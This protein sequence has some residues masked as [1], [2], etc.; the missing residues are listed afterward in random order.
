MREAVTRALLSFCLVSWL[1]GCSGNGAPPEPVPPPDPPPP[2]TVYT[3]EIRRTEYGIPHIMADDW[4]SL[5]YGYGYAYGQDRFCVAMAAIVF[6]TSR[7]AELLGEEYG[8]I[9]ADFVLRYLLGTK[10]EFRERYLSDP[11]DE[12]ILLAEGFAAGMNRYLRETG[13][14]NLPGGDEGCRDAALGLR[15]RCRRCLDAHRPGA[16]IRQFGPEHPA[17]GHDRAGRARRNRSRPATA[18][19][20]GRKSSAPWAGMPIRSGSEA[21]AAT[22]WRWDGI[23]AGRARACCSAIPTSAGAARAAFTNCT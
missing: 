17:P 11:N 3:A 2:E 7:S 1:A 22:P 13:V 12:A 19:P 23:S 20:I 8:D 15:D 16:A 10:D 5:G 18:T 21:T 4:G 9:T 6:A 14:E